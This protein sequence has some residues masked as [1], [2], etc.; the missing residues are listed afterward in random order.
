MRARAVPRQPPA[1][2]ARWAGPD[3][4]NFGTGLLGHPDKG[5]GGRN[6]ARAAGNEEQV[7]R[8]DGRGRHVAHHRDGTA[9]VEEP[10]GKAA[11]LHTFAT[12]PI[13][14]KVAG[15]RDRLDRSVDGRIVELVENRA[16]FLESLSVRAGHDVFLEWSCLRPSGHGTGWSGLRMNWLTV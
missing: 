8:A 11:D 12:A 16:E 7:A 2:R 6:L 13:D 1:A 4:Q 14:R 9:E 3:Y 10:H 15:R 5:D